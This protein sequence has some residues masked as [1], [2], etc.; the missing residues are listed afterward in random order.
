[1]RI[2]KIEA[3]SLFGVFDHTISLNLAD[4]ITIIH[5]L[6]G[7]GKT[8]LLV[9]LK[10][11]FEADFSKFRRIPFKTFALIFDDGSR[12]SL[13][14]RP[15]SPI[16]QEVHRIHY[17]IDIEYS[18]AKAGAQKHTYDGSPD[19]Q[20]R[21][22]PLAIIESQIPEL[23]RKGA[24]TWLNINTGQKLDLQDVWGYG[25]VFPFSRQF[26]K[27]IP[28]W[29]IAVCKS[30]NVRLI[31]AQRLLSVSD[32]KRARTGE[33][34]PGFEPTV[35]SYSKELAASIQEIQARYGTSSQ[36]LVYC[37]TNKWSYA[38]GG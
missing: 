3:V 36:E 28:E 9:M 26:T 7:F 24:D 38:S 30:I 4:R 29:L 5:G 16:P 33:T 10:S 34:V 6:N 25:Q 11:I 14:K 31:E 8:T 13:Q 23:I 20:M 35:S 18:S 32:P 12:L 27:P 22:F 15:S 1:M 2:T 19:K 37:P 17:V 21:R